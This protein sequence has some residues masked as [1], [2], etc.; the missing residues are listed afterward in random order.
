MP[1]EILI[2]MPF[3]LEKC[4]TESEV[5]Q[6]PAL[7]STIAVL[8]FLLAVWRLILWRARAHARYLSKKALHLWSDG[9]PMVSYR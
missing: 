9:T 4:R 1:L 3:L 7:F 6:T 8:A 5:V 2:H